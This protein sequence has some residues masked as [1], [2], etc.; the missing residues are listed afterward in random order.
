MDR[1][2]TGRAQ[3]FI[4]PPAVDKQIEEIIDHQ[5]VRGKGWNNSSSQFLVHWKG[6]V[7]E[8]ATWEK[9]EDLWQFRDKVHSYL[10]VCGTG[11]VAKSGGGVCTAP[12]GA[13]LNFGSFEGEAD[14][15]RASTGL[16][17][18]VKYFPAFGDDLE[19]LDKHVV[20][21]TFSQNGP[22]QRGQG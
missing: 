17:R 6:T 13:T 10:Q 12:Q 1:G 7:P 14:L 22:Q 20:A 16:Q 5:L 21:L 2:Q 11:D 15:Y 3:I 8:E 18:R 4:T 19:N 9:Y